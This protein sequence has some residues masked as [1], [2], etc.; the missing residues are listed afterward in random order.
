MGTSSPN[1]IFSGKGPCGATASVAAHIHPAYR[2]SLRLASASGRDRAIHPSSKTIIWSIS[3]QVR[4]HHSCVAQSSRYRGAL[5]SMS[6]FCHF[7]EIWEG[8]C[9]HS[10]PIL[11]AGGARGKRVGSLLE[12]VKLNS[13]TLSATNLSLIAL[14]F[15]IQRLATI[16]PA[17]ASSSRHPRN[18]HPRKTQPSTYR[19]STHIEPRGYTIVHSLTVPPVQDCR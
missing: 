4:F 15:E 5:Y 8:F 10:L 7:G 9:E 17:T 2:H 12:C 3:T 14:S 16:K 1:F 13:L 19:P 6:K 11:I 18:T